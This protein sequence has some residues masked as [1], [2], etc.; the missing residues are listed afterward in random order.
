MLNFVCGR[1]CGVRGARLFVHM[2]GWIGEARP[3]QEFRSPMYANVLYTLGCSY[4]A[5]FPTVTSKVPSVAFT[6]LHGPAN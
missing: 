6:Q 3:S 5:D 1:L 2:V 4:V